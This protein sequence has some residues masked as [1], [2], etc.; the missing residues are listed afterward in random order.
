MSD[1]FHWP[2]CQLHGDTFAIEPLTRKSS[3]NRVS[4]QQLAIASRQSFC[5]VRA[6]DAWRF[7]HSLGQVRLVVPNAAQLCNLVTESAPD[8][9]IRC[10]IRRH[11][12]EIARASRLIDIRLLDSLVKLATE[13]SFLEE[14][15]TANEIIGLSS[16]SPSKKSPEPVLQ[17]HDSVEPS[18]N[19][20]R[21]QLAAMLGH[22]VQLEQ[23][24]DSIARRTTADDCHPALLGISFH[25]GSSLATNGPESGLSLDQERVA[26]FVDRWEAEA[27][28][29]GSRLARGKFSAAYSIEDGRVQLKKRRFTDLMREWTFTNPEGRLVE[30][31]TDDDGYVPIRPNYWAD[32]KQYK[33]DV[34]SWVEL[35]AVMRLLRIARSN[36]SEVHF[37]ATQLPRLNPHWNW[38]VWE[39]L[40]SS[41]LLRFSHGLAFIVELP[42]LQWRCFAECGFGGHGSKF[43]RECYGRSRRPAQVV[44]EAIE[45]QPERFPSLVG[46]SAE[47]EPLAKGLLDCTCLGMQELDFQRRCKSLGING[48]SASVVSGLYRLISEIAPEFGPTIVRYV[49]F[50]ESK[51]RRR[52]KASWSPETAGYLD[53]AD[54]LRKAVWLELGASGFELLAAS[55]G[56]SL[57]AAP[58]DFTKGAVE[59]GLI[60]TQAISRL[61]ATPVEVAV[62]NYD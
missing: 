12:F 3:N 26:I 54:D 18:M 34:A 58:P 40:I 56:K 42:E 44:R 25:V 62:S 41:R 20:L 10:G 5:I 59:V 1:P 55:P 31:L 49:G 35:D 45:S 52:A 9:V 2:N 19:Q 61:I 4:L 23:S 22:F 57:I 38:S 47:L 16:L 17:D 43:L 32:L 36:E 13:K 8:E 46:L 7:F 11:F 14:P 27:S 51:F 50:A 33:E 24:C 53:L 29:L 37:S 6:A 30:L 60:V 48:V 28:R 21:H 15:P 39:Q